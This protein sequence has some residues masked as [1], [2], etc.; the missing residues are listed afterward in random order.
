MSA[1]SSG[2]CKETASHRRQHGKPPQH[3]A[4]ERRCLSCIREAT[5]AMRASRNITDRR[6]HRLWRS[7]HAAPLRGGRG[8]HLYCSWWWGTA[9]SV[10][11]GYHGWPVTCTVCCGQI[12]NIGRHKK[13]RGRGS[14]E[15]NASDARRLGGADLV[16]VGYIGHRFGRLA[17]RR[18]GAAPANGQRAKMI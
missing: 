11:A 14:R 3:G 17:A 5:S 8:G 15:R 18:T 9:G 12:V 6:S 13:W 1:T 16:V 7:T 2:S 4:Q 10:A